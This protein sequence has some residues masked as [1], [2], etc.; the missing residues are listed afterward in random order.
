MLQILIGDRV[1]GNG[2]DWFE[3]VVTQ[4]HLDIRGW[5]LVISDDTG[6]AGQTIQTLTL[7]NNSLWSDLRSGTII[8]VSENLPDNISNYNP[9]G[10]KWWI[11]V[12]AKTGASGTY[13]TASNFN[14]SN[15]NWQLTIRDSN[16]TN[17][18]GPVGEGI[19]AISGIGSDEI[20]KLEDNPGP[21]VSEQSN[22]KDGSSS[23]F[24]APNIYS[25]G[26]MVQNFSEL[27]TIPDTVAPTPNPMTWKTLPTVT[28]SNSITMIATTASDPA[29]LSII[30]ITLQTRPISYNRFRPGRR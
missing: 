20:C 9:A 7:T 14:V 2:G 21:F 8:T 13:I 25:G 23:T 24:G 17:V 22:Y 15:N 18:F 16:G 27:R 1:L 30:S 5:Q 29:A 6:G 10:D 11:N 3:M 12:Q 26:T 19:M 4:D 28:E